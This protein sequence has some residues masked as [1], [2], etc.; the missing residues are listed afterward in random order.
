MT[1]PLFSSLLIVYDSVYSFLAVNFKILLPV[2]KV[3]DVTSLSCLKLNRVLSNLQAKQRRLF[4]FVFHREK[5]TSLLEIMNDNASICE[6]NG[7]NVHSRRLFNT[8]YGTVPTLHTLSNLGSISQQDDKYWS[9][10]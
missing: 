9:P 10:S 6:S 3:S 8:T 5:V 2:L 7:D 4:L 1:S